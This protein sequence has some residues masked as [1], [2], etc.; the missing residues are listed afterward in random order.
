MNCMAIAVD[1]GF[2]KLLSANNPIKNSAETNILVQRQFQSPAFPHFHISINA[3][4]P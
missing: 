1:V 2:E 3:K 4:D